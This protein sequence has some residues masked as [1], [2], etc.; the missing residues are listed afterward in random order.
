[1][2]TTGFWKAV[3]ERAVKA[4]ASTLSAVLL[5]GTTAVNVLHIEWQDAVGVAGGAA[6]VSVLLNVA[7]GAVTN[8]PGPSLTS[9]EQVVPA[10]PTP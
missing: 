6:L 7:S 4:F 9:A 2:W 3:A 10:P 5:A 8:S 1:M